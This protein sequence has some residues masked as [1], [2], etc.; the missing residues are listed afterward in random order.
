MMRASSSIV[1]AFRSLLDALRVRYLRDP[2]FRRRRRADRH[3]II[4]VANN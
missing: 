1:H 2:A 4:V 3:S